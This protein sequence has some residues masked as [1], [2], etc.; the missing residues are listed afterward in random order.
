VYRVGYM[1]TPD[2]AGAEFALALFERLGRQVEGLTHVMQYTSLRSRRVKEGRGEKLWKRIPEAIRGWAID[3]LWN[4]I[5]EVVGGIGKGWRV[6]V[7]EVLSVGTV[8]EI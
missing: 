1:E 6:P 2:L 4:G 5:D 3:V 8:A 7:A